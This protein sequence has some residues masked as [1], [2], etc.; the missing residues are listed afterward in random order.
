MASKAANT[1]EVTETREEAAEGP[2][3]DTLAAAIKKIL[4]R[5]KER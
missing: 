3:L 2:L 1:A 4:A 5:G